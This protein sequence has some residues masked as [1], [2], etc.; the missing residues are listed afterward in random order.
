M[1][2]RVFLET[3]P[4]HKRELQVRLT[5]LLAD[6][7]GKAESNAHYADLAESL[8]GYVAEV[9]GERC[10]LVLFE[11]HSPKSG[12]VSWMGV[13]PRRQRHGVGRALLDAL[14]R[15]FR[16]DGGRYLFVA[17]LHPNIDYEPYQR[18][19]RFYEAV[20]FEYVLKE[21]FPADPDNP[22]AFY[23]KLV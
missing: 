20:G 16:N 22:T 3:S 14:A 7:F 2:I 1:T 13:E 9:D 17:T 6:W 5:A 11:R 10:G 4:G 21:Q 8:D 19:R 15:D 18:T 23:L 12:E